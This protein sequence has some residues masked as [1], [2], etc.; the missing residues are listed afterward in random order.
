M[1]DGF[2]E[3]SD[4]NEIFTSSAGDEAAQ[5]TLLDLRFVGRIH[6]EAGLL[7]LKHASALLDTSGE[8][9]VETLKALAFFSF[10]VN[11]KF[12]FYFE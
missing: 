8:A 2:I 4:A 1:S 10:D 3:L 9:S 11:H 7:H 6:M 5:G 12:P